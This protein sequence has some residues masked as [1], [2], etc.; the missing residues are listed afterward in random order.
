MV[1]WWRGYSARGGSLSIRRSGNDRVK[2][3]SPLSRDQCIFNPH[4][5]ISSSFC[6]EK[7]S[8]VRHSLICDIYVQFGYSSPGKIFI[9]CWVQMK[10]VVLQMK[11]KTPLTKDAVVNL[12]TSAHQCV[13][14]HVALVNLTKTHEKVV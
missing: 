14:V 3:N 10:E 6:V 4:A 13:K 9:C 7:Y 2:P 8:L 11:S 5:I 12:I 1:C